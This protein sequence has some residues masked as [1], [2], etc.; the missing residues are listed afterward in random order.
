MEWA[1]LVLRVV[2]GA[3]FVAQGVRKVLA[4]RDAP[5]G[6]GNLESL[7]AQQPFPRPD[8]LASLV[9]I[10]ELVGG[11]LL[12]VGFLTRLATVPLAVVLLVAIFG[13]KWRQGF[14][15]GWDWPFSVLGLLAAIALL[16]AGPISIDAVL[17]VP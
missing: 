2:A 10:T 16:G 3:I 13:S 1:A 15:G 8:L 5:H 9:G 11:V 12:L 4:P 14:L 6:R 17:G 7:I